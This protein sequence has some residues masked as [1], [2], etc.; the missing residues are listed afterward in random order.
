MLVFNP[1]NPMH[2]V[3]A[4]KSQVAEAG[5]AV[6]RVS[7]NTPI[8]VEVRNHNKGLTVKVKQVGAETHVSFSGKANGPTRHEVMGGALNDM[9]KY[10]PV[11]L[12]VAG[13][14]APTKDAFGRTNYTEANKRNMVTSPRGGETGRDLADF[15]AKEINRSVLAFRATVKPGTTAGSATLVITRR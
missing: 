8:P 2:Y 9:V 15:F 7:R 11:S 6:S 14:E 3:S 4:W 10:Y 5:L 13:K 12:D 1:F